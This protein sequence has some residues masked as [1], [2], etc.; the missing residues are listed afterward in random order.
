MTQYLKRHFSVRM[1][2]ALC[3][4]HTFVINMDKGKIDINGV[5]ISNNFT[6]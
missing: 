5:G 6:A 4:G 2:C 3:N 1:K